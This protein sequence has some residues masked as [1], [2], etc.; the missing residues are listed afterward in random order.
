MTQ[1]VPAGH[2]VRL[3]AFDRP[4]WTRWARRPVGID[5]TASMFQAS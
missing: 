1:D 2:N 4:P 5:G 3:R